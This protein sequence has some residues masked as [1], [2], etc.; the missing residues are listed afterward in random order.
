MRTRA[1]AMSVAAALAA[2][3]TDATCPKDM[4]TTCPTP[5]PS[6]ANDVAP[7]FATY[8][9]DCHSP[10]GQAPDRPFQTYA[11]IFARRTSVLSFTYGCQMPPAAFPQPTE[12]ERVTLL[13]WLVCNAPNN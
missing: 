12:E 5:T 13:G 2:C 8:C 11:E 1:L 3:G 10:T 7:I 6:Y 4:P 9:N